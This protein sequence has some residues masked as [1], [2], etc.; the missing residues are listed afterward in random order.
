MIVSNVLVYYFFSWGWREYF[1]VI[2]ASFSSYNSQLTPVH[3]A[4]LM[5]APKQE[6]YQ[7]AC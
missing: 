2:R 6:D 7:T 4:Y 3:Q 1:S 5:N